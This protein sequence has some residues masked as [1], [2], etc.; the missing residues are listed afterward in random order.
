MQDP[1][2]TPLY[3]LEDHALIS[4]SGELHILE[5]KQVHSDGVSLRTRA[6]HYTHGSREPNGY[7]RAQ[8]TVDGELHRFAMHRMV[9]LSFVGEPPDGKPLAC[10]INGQRADNWL[11]NLYWGDYADNGRDAVRHG[12]TLKG[13]NATQAKL[14]NA[15]A[16]ELIDRYEAGGVAYQALSD[17]YGLTKAGVSA[18]VKGKV[19]PELR[20]DP[21]KS[22]ANRKANAPRGSR[23]GTTTLSD[24]TVLAIREDYAAN[25]TSSRKLAAKYGVNRTSIRAIINRTTWKHL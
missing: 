18:I 25:A 12:T 2:W 10:H 16:Q 8:I 5:R 23:A 14:T 9:L 11:E 19:R 6:E 7:M 22:A 17:E 4:T 13:E 21:A 1:T 24:E 20:R 15:E 3:G